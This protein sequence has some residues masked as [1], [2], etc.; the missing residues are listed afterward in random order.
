MNWGESNE[1]IFAA[2]IGVKVV[3]AQPRY[4]NHPDATRRSSFVKKICRGLRL[5]IAKLTKSATGPTPLLQ[6]IC[7]PNRLWMTCHANNM[8][9]GDAMTSKWWD[10]CWWSSCQE[11]APC[12]P[13]RK[14]T[15]PRWWTSTET[16]LAHRGWEMI[17]HEPCLKVIQLQDTL[18]SEAI[19]HIDD[20]VK[21]DAILRSSLTNHFLDF[22]LSKMRGAV[23]VDLI[24]STYKGIPRSSPFSRLQ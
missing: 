5:G 13:R 21:L 12:R 11:V 19:L 16:Y 4:N 14:N 20:D 9:L 6:P 1:S 8:H 23:S 3:E 18:K 7:C 24:P 17:V 10:S 22:D 15:R 2:W